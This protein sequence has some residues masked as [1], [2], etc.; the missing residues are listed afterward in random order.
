MDQ[1][2]PIRAEYCS[3]PNQS[4]CDCDWCRYVRA[5]TPPVDSTEELNPNAL[6]MVEYSKRLAP[7]EAR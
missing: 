2:K 5:W 7:K 1:T 4:W 3:H 6:G